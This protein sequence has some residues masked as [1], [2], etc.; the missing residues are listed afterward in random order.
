MVTDSNAFEFLTPEAA[1][2]LKTRKL[3]LSL[4]FFLFKLASVSSNR[5]NSH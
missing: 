4:S 3:I 5:K 1:M 2:Y